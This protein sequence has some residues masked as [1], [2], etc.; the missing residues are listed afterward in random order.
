MQ[1]RILTIQ[2]ISCFGKCSLT[3]ALPIISAMGVETAI[4]PTAVLSTHT[5][6]FKNF[7]FRDLTDDIPKIVSH[8]KSIKLDFD[9]IYTG[10][11]GSFE[12]L[13]VIKSFADDFK[14]TGRYVLFG[15]IALAVYLA[16]V[17]VLLNGKK[18][19]H[20]MFR[21]FAIVTG[22]SGLTVLV[23]SLFVK[24]SG[25]LEQITFA[26]T[27]REYNLFMNF[28]NDFVALFTATGV[29]WTVICIVLLVLWY[30]S[31]TGKLKK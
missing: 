4:I 27:Q 15:L 16:L 3:V 5:G 30:M 22:S 10:Y 7:T 17:M 20:R 13:D 29:F 1:K 11:L 25:I 18:Q 31:V 19:K 9:V 24:F 6:G 26:P 12:Q 28:F 21:R 23:F 8:W 2:D 14:T